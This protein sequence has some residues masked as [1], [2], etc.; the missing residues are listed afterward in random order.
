MRKFLAGLVLDGKGR[1]NSATGN[2]YSSLLKNKRDNGGKQPILLNNQKHSKVAHGNPNL[3]RT[4]DDSFNT[5][6]LPK[7]YC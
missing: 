1:E 4:M 3:C 6:P 5:S 2:L 7:S